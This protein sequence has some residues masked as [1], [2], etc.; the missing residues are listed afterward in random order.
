MLSQTHKRIAH[1]HFVRGR[2]G[3][4]GFDRSRSHQWH[5]RTHHRRRPFTC[6][7]GE[8]HSAPV[9]LRHHGSSGV[10]E[11]EHLGELAQAQDARRASGGF[12]RVDERNATHFLVIS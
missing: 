6:R 5:H 12:R 2:G 9:F 7:N 8:V 4:F 10:D 11:G 3:G 1:R